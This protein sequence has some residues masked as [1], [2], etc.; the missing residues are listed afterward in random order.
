[1][2]GKIM[3][4]D[5]LA[6][7]CNRSLGQRYSFSVQS[8]LNNPGPARD[9]GIRAL[10]GAVVIGLKGVFQNLSAAEMKQIKSTSLAV[11]MDYL[12]MTARRLFAPD[13]VDFHI[14]AS[15]SGQ[16]HLV[17]CA[18]RDRQ[19]TG[20]VFYLPHHWDPRLTRQKPQQDQWAV[21]YFGRVENAHIPET[22]RSLLTQPDYGKDSD[23]GQVLAQMCRT[24][25]HYAVRPELGA[26]TAPLK[27]FTKG[28]NA[29][30]CG[31]NII[32]TADTTDAIHYLGKDYPYLLPDSSDATILDCLARAKDDFGGPVWND[33]LDRMQM[34]RKRTAPRMV[35][36]HMGKIL[37]Q[38]LA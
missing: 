24:P 13:F 20:R 25:L 31:A 11:G 29:A 23:F 30:A 32:C 34:L 35:A 6:A 27:P 1:M 37:D 28:F 21:A 5:Q 14:S 33:A 16:R 26:A 17:A 15:V 18:K 3:R 4:C 38:V 2:G 22:A 19:A 8:L 10:T 36:R 12:D 7:I 9:A